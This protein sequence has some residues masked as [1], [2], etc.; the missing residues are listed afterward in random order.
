MT[1]DRET[2]KGPS[3]RDTGDQAG[4]R[5]AWQYDEMKASG[6]DYSDARLAKDYDA[7]HQRFRDYRRQAETIM[8]LLALDSSATLIDMGC[9][10]G[11]FAIHAAE[12]Y[13]KIYAV[14]V[15]PAMLDLARAK[16]NEAG[17]ANI[18]FHHG[19]F[20]TYEHQVEPVDAV[21]STVALHHL[22]DFWKQVGL[23]RLAQM[24]RPGGRLYL[25]DVIFS[26]GVE[27]YATS[28]PQFIDTM[29]EQMG[30]TGRREPE[31][32]VRDEYSTY[33]W[34]MEGMFERVGFQIDQVNYPNEFLAGYLC[35]KKVLSPADAALTG[36]TRPQH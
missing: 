30:P 6:V 20:L 25:F 8:N 24:I 10:T 13:R 9:G 18:E 28:V 22:P 19:G 36:D 31:T 2:D 11:A 1:K 15:S 7:R 3:A 32:H 26:F 21:V 23:Y 14:D 35:T 27:S 12:R 33:Q 16:A 29:S 4:E 5:P 17:L 34:I